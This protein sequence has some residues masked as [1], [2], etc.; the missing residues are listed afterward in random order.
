MEPTV[1]HLIATSESVL[2]SSSDGKLLILSTSGQLR[3]VHSLAGSWARLVVDAN[4]TLVAA[5]NRDALFRWERDRFRHIADV[6][7]EGVGIWS[8]GL[9]MWDRKRLDVLSWTGQA[10]WSVEFSK[11]ISSAV[12]QEERLICAAGV[13]TAFARPSKAI[14]GR[15]ASS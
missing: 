9:Y 15:S 1:S 6:T 11:N 14:P 3:E 5:Y 13:L 12:V 8:E 7:A 10:V 4:G 2:V